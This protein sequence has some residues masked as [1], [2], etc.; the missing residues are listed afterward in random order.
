MKCP[1]KIKICIRCKKIL[2]AN[3]MNFYKSKVT[4][5]NLENQCKKC[6]YEKEKENKIFKEKLKEKGNPFDNIDIDKVWN[7]CPFCIRVCSKCGGI[8]VANDINF[9]KSKR[10][11]KYGLRS[12]CKRCA[13]NYQKEERCDYQKKYYQDNKETILEKGKERY[14]N[15]KETILERNKK[16]KEN[17]KEKFDEYQKKYHEEHKIEKAEYK[18]QWGKNN[19]EK[20]FNSRCRRR[21]NIEKKNDVTKEQWIEMM[22]FFDWKCAYSGEKLNDKNRSTD[23]ILSLDKGGLNVIWNLVP[24][25]RNYNSSKHTK[26]M[27]EWY[28]QQDFYNEDRLNKIYEWQEY[29][30]KKWGKE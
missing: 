24:M 5:D 9:H 26:D 10:D 12:I 20:R 2:V 14:E 22:Q 19:P 18:K 16:W 29:A 15:N 17:N 13:S 3:D 7:H 23:H 25:V 11:K 8:L 30:F 6:K 21:K 1:F 27:V 4:K 28:K